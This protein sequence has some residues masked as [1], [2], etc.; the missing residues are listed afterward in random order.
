MQV[1]AA[2]LLEEAHRIGRALLGPLPGF[3]DG[4]A[5]R[6]EALAA[7]SRKRGE[8]TV[9]RWIEYRQGGHR[10]YT[11]YLSTGGGVT[12][13]ELPRDV[14]PESVM[15]VEIA[16]D[17]K[18]VT[19]KLYEFYRL[20]ERL[21]TAQTV[22]ITGTN[23]EIEFVGSSDDRARLHLLLK[24]I[25]MIRAACDPSFPRTVLERYAERFKQAL[26]TD[27]ASRNVGPYFQ[28]TNAV[29]DEIVELHLNLGVD[30][31]VAAWFRV[32]RDVCQA[33]YERAQER[34]FDY[35]QLFALTL[36]LSEFGCMPPSPDPASLTDTFA[37]SVGAAM[38][39]HSL[40]TETA[41]QYLEEG[42]LLVKKAIEAATKDEHGRWLHQAGV[43][44]MAAHRIYEG[45]L[46]R[47]IKTLPSETRKL[48]V[49]ANKKAEEETVL[50]ANAL[51]FA[52]KDRNGEKEEA[53]AR[54]LKQLQ[55]TQG[56]RA[57]DDM[58]Y[59][60]VK[61][62]YFYPQAYVGHLVEFASKLSADGVQ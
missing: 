7:E 56:Q 50:V 53:F 32:Y 25:R 30:S 17:D 26:P 10:I 16:T 4:D 33:L 2:G 20:V 39:L 14:D 37:F 5:V 45:L 58:V 27:P 57:A 41:E 59:Q 40:M 8:Q 60:W 46:E 6:E 19:E 22:A 42:K 36:K 13:K 48:Y 47:P 38:G 1:T 62:E 21:A 3:A 12:R 44:F 11:R 28:A 54:R 24:Y 51:L 43:V 31:L 34:R 52:F 15:L 49:A 55:A 35:T 29:H 18:P 61:V 23:E 9:D